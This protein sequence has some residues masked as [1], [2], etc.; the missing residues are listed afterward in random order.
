[1]TVL[2]TGAAGY[3][4]A[5]VVSALLDAGD[6]VVGVD[7]LSRGHR[8]F[9][10]RI[11]HVVGDVADD[12][13][14]R[15]AFEQHA[16]IDAV[17]HCAART[18]VGDS[19][20][21]PLTYYRENVGKTLQL[22]QTVLDLGCRRFVFSSS[23]AVYGSAPPPV[24]DETAPVDAVS[25]YAATKLVVERVLDDLAAAGDVQAASLRYFNPVGADPD[26]RNGRSDPASPDVL[27][28]L[29]ASAGGRFVVNGT[30]WDTPDGSPVRDFVHVADVARAHVHAVHRSGAAPAGHDVIN[31]GSGRAT[32]IRQLATT[33]ARLVPGG[34]RI[35]DGPRRPGDTVG[36]RADISRA[37][38]LLGWQPRAGLDDAVRDAV[39]WSAALATSE[40]TP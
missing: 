24:V 8:P 4:G 32:T 1:M 13:V 26:L 3:V 17:I 16:G 30:D 22:L 28:A 9:L 11:P 12:A 35:V 27:T 20:V 15:A 23:A 2:V 40:L 18:I 33:V 14:V 6:E 5:A 38:R 34:L 19:V 29:L 21:D 25:P 37:A 39:R 7:D 10:E 36:C 31:I